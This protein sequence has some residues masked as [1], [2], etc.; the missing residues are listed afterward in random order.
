MVAFKLPGVAFPSPFLPSGKSCST[1]LPPRSMNNKARQVEHK[2]RSL[3]ICGEEW[4][5]EV[6]LLEDVLGQ[7][8][9]AN[10]DDVHQE[11]SE[12]AQREPLCPCS[13]AEALT[14]HALYCLTGPSKAPRGHLDKYFELLSSS[15][16]L[17]QKTECNLGFTGHNCNLPCSPL[18]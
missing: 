11:E 4:L 10:P 7:L 9:G 3:Q 13:G 2:Q 6:L 8:R 1:L 17:E 16:H 14:G 5:V 18:Q 12:D 15:I